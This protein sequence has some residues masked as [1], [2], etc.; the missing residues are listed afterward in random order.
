MHAEPA[1]EQRIYSGFCLTP[2]TC[3]A[4]I[5]IDAGGRSGK[6]AVDFLLTAGELFTLVVYGQLI[7]ENAGIYNVETE[8]LDQIF[9]FIVRL[10]EI[11]AADVLQAQQQRRADGAVPENEGPVPH[12][13][14]EWRSGWSASPTLNAAPSLTA[15]DARAGVTAE[16]RSGSLRQ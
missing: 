1:Q 7:L 3:F 16:R 5:P 12:A 13:E 6:R 8:V 11:R 10:L 9:D 14:V 2:G 15:H 4:T